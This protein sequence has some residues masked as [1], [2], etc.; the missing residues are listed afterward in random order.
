VLSVVVPA[1]REEEYIEGTLQGIAV[2]LRDARLRSEIIVVV[3]LVPEDETGSHVRKV[4]HVYP[5]IHVIERRGKR[6]VG[7]AVTTGIKQ[8]HGQVVI[9]AMGDGSDHPSDIVR[10]AKAA[11]GCDIVFTERFK[12]GRPPGYPVLKYIANRCCNFAAM[13]LFRIPY[14]D[15]TNAFK[16]YRKELLDWL[17]LSSKGFE[18]FLEVPIKAIQLARRTK[19]I[20]VDHIVKR[21]KVSKLSITR[22]GYNYVRVLLSLIRSE[23]R[24]GRDQLT[25]ST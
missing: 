24:R 20:E 2:A 22:D 7:D 8:S 23:Q 17:S 16:A 5:E 10:L 18:I 25:A 12:H 3:D 13:V 9:I 4:S 19:V 15:T 1:Y 21:R 14:S 6:G 11:E